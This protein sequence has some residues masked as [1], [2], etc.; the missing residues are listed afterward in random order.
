MYDLYHYPPQGRFYNI[1]H[2][3]SGRVA[4]ALTLPVAYHCIF[5]LGFAPDPTDTRVVVHSLLG[6]SLYGVFVGKVL[7]VRS[8]GFPG[9]ALPI[10]GSLLFT[11]L[12]GLWL[13]SALWFF[14]TKGVAL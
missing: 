11:V 8:K 4:I 5:L 7:I 9:W 14:T 12:L 13:S 10:A 6:C 3:W 1:V 2:R